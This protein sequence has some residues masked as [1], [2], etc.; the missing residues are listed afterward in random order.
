MDKVEID[1][2]EIREVFDCLEDLHHFLHQPDNYRSHE[3]IQ[4][5]LDNGAYRRLHRA[6]YETVW[7]WLPPEVQKE[8]RDR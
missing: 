3:Q 7:G 5:F 8:Y 1:I 6:Y 4:R 2:A